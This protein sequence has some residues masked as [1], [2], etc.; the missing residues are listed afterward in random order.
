MTYRLWINPIAWFSNAEVSGRV[1]NECILTLG[2]KPTIKRNRNPNFGSSTFPTYPK[3]IEKDLLTTKTITPPKFNSEFSPAKIVGK[4]DKPFLLGP[5]NFSGENSLVKL[6]EGVFLG[7]TSLEGTS[8]WPFLLG[9]FTYMNAWF[10]WVFITSVGIV[11]KTRETHVPM[12]PEKT[13]EIFSQKHPHQSPSQLVFCFRNGARF[14]LAFQY[15]G[16]ESI[17]ECWLSSCGYLGLCDDLS[18]L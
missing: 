8:H 17:H 11:T 13:G 5:G 15:D 10:L 4:E 12:D 3:I 2:V 1:S 6:W 18:G 16:A 14:P 7:W 9:W